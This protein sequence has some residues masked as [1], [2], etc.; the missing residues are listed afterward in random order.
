MSDRE[1][2][3]EIIREAIESWGPVSNAQF[4]ADQ[5]LALIRPGEPTTRKEAFE[6]LFDVHREIPGRCKPSVYE[7]DHCPC[8]EYSDEENW[9]YLWTRAWQPKCIYDECPHDVQPSEPVA[10]EDYGFTFDMVPAMCGVMSHYEKQ[11]LLPEVMETLQG[12]T[13]ALQRYLTN[14][15]APQ[16]EREREA[17]GMVEGRYPVLVEAFEIHH[18]KSLYCIA[19]FNG[20]PWLLWKHPD[21]QWVTEQKIRTAIHSSIGA[22]YGTAI[23]LGPEDE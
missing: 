11:G 18:P 21:G 4:F 3:I 16:P 12:I 2:V 13:D 20:E 5:I 19:R 8:S 14:N 10:W 7:G 22:Q 6:V 9:E 15:P 17:L 1:K 23:L